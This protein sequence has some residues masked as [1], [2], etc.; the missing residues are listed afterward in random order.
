MKGYKRCV[1]I[2]LSLM[3]TACATEPE[4]PGFDSAL[5]D[6]LP[7]D[8]LTSD[9]PPLN[10]KEAIMRGDIALSKNNIDLALY[11]YIRSLS[12]PDGQYHDKSLYNIG[13]IHESRGNL[14]LAQKAY[15]IALEENPNNVQVLEH[16]GGIYAKSGDVEQGYSYFLRALNADQVRLN[17]SNTLNPDDLVK[18]GDV[19]ALQVDNDSPVTAYMGLGVLTDVKANHTLAQ[20]F[21]KKALLIEPRSVKVQINTGYSYYMSGDYKTALKYTLSAL[22]QEP[23]NEKAQNNLALIYLSRGEIKRAINVFM[24]QMDAAEALNNVGYFLILQGK[25][26]KA[27]PY[28]Q[29]AIDKKPSY[30]KVANENLERALAEV[31]ANTV[32]EPIEAKAE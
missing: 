10:E 30:Y 15:S 9:A 27:I 4:K 13:R 16:L 17:S 18:S 28:L 25:P 32:Q 3:L 12:F 14:P 2:T 24:R 22:E 31:R 19:E 23:N 8:T 11:E 6:G 21:Y 29:Q 7:V 5:Y 26:D 20:A 1:V